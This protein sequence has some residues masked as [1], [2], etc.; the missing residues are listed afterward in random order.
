[1]TTLE[2][3]VTLIKASKPRQNLVVP[4]VSW[5]LATKES[6]G[7]HECDILVLSK[8]GWATEIEIKISK[9]D[10]LNDFKKGHN[11]KHNLIRKLYYAVP[12]ELRVIA[13]DKIPDTAGLMT[14][15]Y[16]DAINYKWFDTGGRVE[17]PYKYRRVKT[18]REAQINKD[19]R[20]WN[21]DE[22]YQLARLG[23]MR[24]LGLKEKLLSKLQPE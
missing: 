20:K 16:I 9:S 13:L 2:M 10:L 5:G 12:E 18:I 3:E 22:R 8:S 1:M 19:A 23:T 4:N 11:H 17:I 6:H 24:I 15:E 7:L 14:V 21:G